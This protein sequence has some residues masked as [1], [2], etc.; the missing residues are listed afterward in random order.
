[1]MRT[2]AAVGIISAAALLAGCG[3]AK[4]A[5]RP[6]SVTALASKLGCTPAYVITTPQVAGIDVTKFLN[7][8]C[9]QSTGASDDI[10]TFSSAAKMT[11]WLH[12]NTTAETG[13]AIGDGYAECVTGQLWI[14]CPS[15]GVGEGTAIQGILGGKVVDF[16]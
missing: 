12:E 15:G 7:A 16:G 9:N 13:S 14:V 11:D 2:R 6:P 10:M 4:A 3:A 8:T 1:M 5:A